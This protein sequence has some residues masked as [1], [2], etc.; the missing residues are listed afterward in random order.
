MKRY[1]GYLIDLDGTLFRGTELIPGALSFIEKLAGANI[2]FLYL[3]NN[4][5]RPPEQV[6]EKLRGF[7]FPA[8]PDQVYTS[9]LATAQYLKEEMDS[10][11]V[12]VI[13][14]EGLKRAIREAGICINE[15][16]P[17]AVVVGIDRQFTYEKMK[18]AC[19]AIRNG[20]TLIGTNADR[21]LPTEEGLLPGSGSLS[22]GIA[23]ASGV[24]PLFIGKPEP[25]IM[26]YAL[27]KLGTSPEETLVVG[28]NL[29]TDILAG[30][31]G[32]MDTLLVFSGITTHEMA[33]KSRIRATYYL[34]S[35]RDWSI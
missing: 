4:S 22:I 8:E 18:R 32:G 29:E 17:E 26:K 23:A 28:D 19:L 3:T 16:Q 9:A 33:N 35:L 24:E 31:R 14:E 7:G 20:A 21:A 13:G 15:E 6:A 34:D 5:S 1:R 30:I 2:P 12:F 25:I 10:P 11:S 27:E